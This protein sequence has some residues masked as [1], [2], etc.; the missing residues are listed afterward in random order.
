MKESMAGMAIDN[1]YESMMTA[2]EVA[3]L[4]C[5]HVNTV[6]RWSNRG[7][8]RGYRISIRGDMRFPRESIA[9][10]M[11]KLHANNGDERKAGFTQT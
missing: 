7:I 9:R 6:R 1:H 8:L 5:V 3:Q 2:R 4:L 10:F 11:A